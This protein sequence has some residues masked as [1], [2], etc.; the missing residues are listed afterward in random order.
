MMENHLYECIY[1]VLQRDSS[2]QNIR[3]IAN[4]L[5]AKIVRLHSIRMQ[6]FLLDTEEAYRLESEQP[7]LYH[8]L[9]MKRRLSQRTIHTLR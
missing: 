8:T 3:P 7:M 1:D 5:K 2:P 6:R 4:R 9:Q